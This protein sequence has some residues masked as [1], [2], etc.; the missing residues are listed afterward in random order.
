MKTPFT[1]L[2]RLVLCLFFLTNIFCYSPAQSDRPCGAPWMPIDN[3]TNAAI[4]NFDNAGFQATD[5]PMPGSCTG[6]Y[7]RDAWVR[8][9]P[10][11]TTMDVSFSTFRRFPNP[12]PNPAQ[13]DAAIYI[14]TPNCNTLSLVA[15]CQP[16]CIFGIVCIEG[17][18]LEM[19]GEAVQFSGL[20]IG[21]EYYMRFF[22]DSTSAPPPD[23][24][25]ISFRTP[26]SCSPC[27][28]C[29]LP[30]EPLDI[31]DLLLSAEAGPQGLRLEWADFSST[32]GHSATGYFVEGS[33][34]RIGWHTLQQGDFA[35]ISANPPTFT[36]TL[37]PRDHG[38][39][40]WFRIGKQDLN[41]EVTY[42]NV[43]TVGP[44]EVTL[45]FE[46]TW[47]EEG[48]LL[49]YAAEA[50]S[51]IRISDL[52]GKVVYMRE[53]AEGINSLMVPRDFFT[54]GAYVVQMRNA[55]GAL[56]KKIGI[57]F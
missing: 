35:S 28:P 44:T 29:G 45:H 36:H 8:F 51:R 4:L 9:N 55:S 37:A 25:L 23:T 52:S 54:S 53:V 16:R 21:Q 42:S 20:T 24:F 26:G 56:T 6:N 27:P 31:G 15:G 1:R 47:R 38:A 48:L 7:T 14:A 57:G 11:S 32:P 39:M 10:P 12:L 13:L 40:R 2:L 49:A 41:G 50:A 34:D 30:R 19:A 18:D 46:W 3:C 5:G 43:V 22:W 33:Q 17:F